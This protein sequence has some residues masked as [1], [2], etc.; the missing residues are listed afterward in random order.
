MEVNAYVLRAVLARTELD[1]EGAAQVGTSIKEN[2]GNATTVEEALRNMAQFGND[3]SGFNKYVPYLLTLGR[4]VPKAVNGAGITISGSS[5]GDSYRVDAKGL[6]STEYDIVTS[7]GGFTQIR[8]NLRLSNQWLMR[9]VPGGPGISLP[10]NILALAEPFPTTFAGDQNNI[11][12]TF[13]ITIDSESGELP[14]PPAGPTQWWN[15]INWPGGSPPA[16]PDIGG[17]T[18]YAFIKIGPNNY[19][20]FVIGSQI[21]HP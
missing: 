15:N 16:G 18:T 9:F 6:I 13:T 4:Q 17:R 5:E 2:L 3:L 12:T 11:G 19:D 21:P 10:V 7:S 14:S 1:D 8:P 20:G